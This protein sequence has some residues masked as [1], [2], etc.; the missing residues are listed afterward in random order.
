MLGFL[1]GLVTG[2]GLYWAWERFLR[3]II[4]RR[5]EL[6]PVA[7]IEMPAEAEVHGRPDAPLPARR[8]PR[9]EPRHPTAEEMP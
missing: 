1:L 6:R 2:V 3:P 7:R 9:A 5:P 4:V 8:P